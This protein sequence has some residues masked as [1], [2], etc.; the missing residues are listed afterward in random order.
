MVLVLLCV[1]LTGIL[2][3]RIFPKEKYKIITDYNNLR[4]IFGAKQ[5]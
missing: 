1:C 2:Y 3:D 5:L 4:L